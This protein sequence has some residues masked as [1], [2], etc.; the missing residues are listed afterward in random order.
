[1]NFLC[2]DALKDRVAFVTGATRGIGLAI[3]KTLAQSGAFVVGT[4]TSEAGAAKISEELAE[5][6]RGI[7]LDVTNAEAA[8]AA[9]NAVAS[10]FG[11]LDILVNSAGITRDQI[12]MRM[13]DEAWDAVIATNLTAAFRLCRAAMRP[14]MKQR[15]GKIVNIADGERRSGELFG[16]EGGRDRAGQDDGE[17]VRRAEYSGERGGA[18]IH[19]N[20]YD[21][22]IV[23]GSARCVSDGDS[24]EAR[25]PSGR[26]GERGLFPLFSGF[27]LRDRSGDQRGRWNADVTGKSRLRG[28]KNKKNF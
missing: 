28:V 22:E 25:R 14:M 10:E 5:K 1:M 26:C 19:R 13:S 15:S 6:G 21:R 23:A 8:V 9:L 7:V 17:G 12:S 27:R 16:V 4:A 24:G 20:R 3:A 11:R 18:G 2:A